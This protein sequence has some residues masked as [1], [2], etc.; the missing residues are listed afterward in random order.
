MA[1]GIMPTK[2]SQKKIKTEKGRIENGVGDWNLEVGDW[3]LE[4][5]G[6]GLEVVCNLKFLSYQ[7]LVVIYVN[8]RINLRKSA[9]K[10][11]PDVN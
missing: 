7:L 10:N 4:V 3:R 8:Q 2:I 9:R 11:F 5:G 6:W 1:L